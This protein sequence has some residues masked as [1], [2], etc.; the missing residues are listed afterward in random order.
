MATNDP[1]VA[2]DAIL[3]E[4][5]DRV[6]AR[7]AKHAKPDDGPEF[8]DIRTAAKLFCLAPT[9]VER[10]TKEGRLSAHR[11]GKKLV[12]KTSDLRAIVEA[13]GP[14]RGGKHRAPRAPAVVPSVDPN[15]LSPA[16]ILALP[17]TRPLPLRRGK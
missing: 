8:V 16:E 10:W 11:A 4:L 6:A 15:D 5:A 9:T 14:A 12:I 2:L 7:L 3:N 1:L 13:Q 17:L